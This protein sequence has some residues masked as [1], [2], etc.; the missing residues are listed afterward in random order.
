MFPPHIHMHLSPPEITGIPP[1]KHVGLAGI[2]GVTIAGTHG[3]GVKTPRAAAVAAAT[4][5]LESVL[6]IPN[7]AIFTIGM[8]SII[9]ARGNPAAKTGNFGG[10]T[11]GT[12]ATPNEQEHRAPQTAIGILI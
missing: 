3:I 11:S 7:V 9:V 5:G 10:T 6:H 8:K 4:V 1:N 2:Q 12:G